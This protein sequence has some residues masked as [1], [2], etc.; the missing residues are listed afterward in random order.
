M[1]A[2]RSTA[3]AATCHCSS[4]CPMRVVRSKRRYPAPGRPPRPLPRRVS[5]PP[6][7]SSASRVMTAILTD[8]SA[9]DGP[10]SGTVCAQGPCP[11]RSPGMT[12][13][14][15]IAVCVLLG[16]LAVSQV[17]LVCRFPLGRFAWGGQ[18]EVL[19]A[20]LRV[21]SVS[22]IAVYVVMGWVVLARA[23]L[24]GGGHGVVRM[25]TWVIAGFFLLGAAGNLGSREPIRARGDDADR[26]GARVPDRDRRSP[27]LSRRTTP[28]LK[29]RRHTRVHRR[30]RQDSWPRGKSLPPLHP[31]TD[32][33]LFVRQ[34]MPPTSPCGTGWPSRPAWWSSNAW[35]DLG[36]GVHHERAGPGDGSRIGRPPRSHDV[37]PRGIPRLLGRRGG[38]LEGVT[39]AEDGELAGADRASG[40]GRR[41]RCRS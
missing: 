37:H 40:R 41:S 21:G 36:V 23:G 12:A 5:R 1:T 22:A 7:R 38:Q 19:P 11:R 4:P 35:T 28:E 14:A 15:A 9:T 20:R 2:H 33:R 24:L 31:R 25:A 3:D 30:P 8:A 13:A 27:G 18:H 17:L 32:G 39:A 16:A 26:S 29:V 6:G 34:A 10:F